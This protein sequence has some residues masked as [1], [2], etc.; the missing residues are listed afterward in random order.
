MNNAFEQIFEQSLWTER[1]TFN[2]NSFMINQFEQKHEQSL[3][4][5]IWTFNLVKKW[6]INSNSFFNN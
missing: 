2:L 6:T 3:W 5:D 4:T 1:Q